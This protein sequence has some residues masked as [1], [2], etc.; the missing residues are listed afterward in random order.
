L[1]LRKLLPALAS[2][3]DK[4]RPAAGFSVVGVA[5][6]PKTNESWRAEIREALDEP[7]RAAFDALAPRVFY[8]QGDVSDEGDTKALAGKLDALPGGKDAGRLYYLSLKPDLFAQAVQNL[9][10]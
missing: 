10:K 1:A 2:L 8:V 9:S 7:L 6:R 3:A 5:R 4:G